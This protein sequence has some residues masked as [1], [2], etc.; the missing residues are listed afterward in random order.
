VQELAN[1]L[2][3][4]DPQ[5]MKERFF[6]LTGPEN[7]AKYVLPK[8]HCLYPLANAGAVFVPTINSASVLIFR[9]RAIEPWNRLD[10]RMPC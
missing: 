4:R 2:I 1:T 8:Y 5:L 9:L 3:S 7:R 10:V 6:D